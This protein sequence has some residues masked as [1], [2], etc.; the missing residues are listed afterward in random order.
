MK[1]WFIVAS[2]LAPM[3]VL[4]ACSQAEAPASQQAAAP[5]AVPA[6]VKSQWLLIA[7]TDSK[8][9]GIYVDP[10]L[11]R[12]DP[13]TGLSDVTLKVVHGDFNELD[14]TSGDTATSPYREEKV[15]FR[16][17]CA[18]KTYALVKREGL[19]KNGD[20][21]ATTAEAITDASYREA[22][23]GGVASVAQGQACVSK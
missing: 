3:L 18:K 7:H 14:A 11:K 21:I 20:V 12:V 8:G 15:T 6:G 10:T 2:L 23:P 16:F 19:N 13:A 17:N 5:A 9:G 4:S 1:S 22:A